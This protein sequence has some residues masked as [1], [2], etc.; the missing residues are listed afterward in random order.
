MTAGISSAS[1]CSNACRILL[2]IAT[3]SARL[4]SPGS[5]LRKFVAAEITVGDSGRQEQKLVRNGNAGPVESVD[6]QAFTLLVYA[7]HLAEDHRDIFLPA[8]N[9][10]NRR[11][12]LSRCQH[13]RSNLIQKRLKYVVIRSIN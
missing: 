2:R 9:A 8:E 6:E 13:R 11:A 3:A 12:N 7:G 4:F 5:E 10:S 1:A